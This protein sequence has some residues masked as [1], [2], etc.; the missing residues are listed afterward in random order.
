M[1]DKALWIA[2]NAHFDQLDKGGRPYILHP[3]TV[4]LNVNT[5]DEK[6]VALLHDVIEDT[7]VTLDDLRKEGFPDNIIEAVNVLTKRDGED[8]ESYLHRV[9]KNHLATTVKIA[10]LKHNSDLSRLKEITDKDRKRAKKYARSLDY[11]MG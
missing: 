9:K 1:L 8:Y 5:T 3:M 11:L 10:D 2:F 7:S 4:A 6:I